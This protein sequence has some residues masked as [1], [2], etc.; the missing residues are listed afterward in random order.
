M[1]KDIKTSEDVRL[2]VDTFYERLKDD[3][4]IGYFFNEVMAVDW[5]AHLPKMYGFWDILL[6]GKTGMLTDPMQKHILIN[7][8]ERI[9]EA[10]FEQWVKLWFETMDA[11]FE[12]PTTELA[13][14]RTR[15]IQ[16]NMLKRIRSSES[17]NMAV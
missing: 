2:L 13:K 14:E 15:A 3:Q 7:A 6:L 16:Q 11:L 8:R 5:E 12:G 9:D 10:H 4:R 1:K 17:G